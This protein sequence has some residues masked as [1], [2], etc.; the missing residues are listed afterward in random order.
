MTL[1]SVILH[2][3]RANPRD[4][5]CLCSSSI[6]VFLSLIFF[7]KTLAC[8]LHNKDPKS[9]CMVRRNTLYVESLLLKA[10]RLSVWP[11]HLHSWQTAGDPERPGPAQCFSSREQWYTVSE[12]S[13]GKQGSF[14][15]PAKAK[16][17]V[18]KLT[19]VNVRSWTW[20]NR[21]QGGGMIWKESH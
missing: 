10:Q 21:W 20:R 17:K 13:P 5:R 4:H 1:M 19:N 6:I 8:S 9:R 16:L 18:G 7:L 2:Y 3:Q 12:L 14:Q 15:E 11:S